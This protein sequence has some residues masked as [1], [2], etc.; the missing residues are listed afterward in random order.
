MKKRQ[1]TPAFVWLALALPASALAQSELILPQNLDDI[2]QL[3]KQA[4]AGPCDKC[5]VVTHISSK[6]R[7]LRQRQNTP[8]PGSP[9]MATTPI[10][11][12]GDVVKEAREPL[13]SSTSYVVTVRYDNGAYAFFEQDDEPTVRRNDRVQVIESRVVLR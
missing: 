8:A 11:G 12:S 3:S 4:E 7:E 2:R 1:K 9:A 5:G 6:Q 10:I 13:T